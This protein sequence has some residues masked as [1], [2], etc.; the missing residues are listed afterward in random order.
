MKAL[1][2]S[3]M[4]WPGLDNDLEMMVESCQECQSVKQTPP[5]APMHPWIWPLKPWQQVHINF[6]GPFLGK[7]FFIAVDAHS[8]WLEVVSDNGTQFTSSEFDKFMKGNGIKHVRCSSY[9][10]LSN[11]A[12]ERFV[13][14]FKEAMKSSKHDGLTFTHRFNNF[15]LK[16]CSSPNSTTSTAPATLLLGRELRTRL[17]LLKPDLERSVG[18][19]QATKK[20][21]HDQH[22]KERDF[23]VGQEVMVRNMR[24]GQDLIPGLIIQQLNPL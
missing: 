21:H 4:W 11:G 13:R 7:M 18:K 2:R 23:F 8:K 1:A 22:S 14:T 15:L 24:P 6:A 16:Y 9:H 12:A 10:P 20:L 19:K 17:H 3:H 5:Q